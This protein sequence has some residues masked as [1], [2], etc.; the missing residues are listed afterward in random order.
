[1]RRRF[2]ATKEDRAAWAKRARKDL[3]RFGAEALALNPLLLEKWQAA[4]RLIGDADPMDVALHWLQRNEAGSTLK[5]EEAVR[6]YIDHVEH[7]FASNE[8]TTRMQRVLDRFSTVAAG[9]ALGAISTE[10]IHRWLMAQRGFKAKTRKN[11]RADLSAFFAYWVGLEALPANPVDGVPVPRDALDEPGTVSPDTARR[12]FEANADDSR[13]TTVLALMCFAGMRSSAISRLEWS[14]LRLADEGILTSA[15]KSKKERRQFLQGFPPVL[16]EWLKRAQA[17]HF[18]RDMPAATGDDYADRKAL[19]AW[20]V[21]EKRR[22]ENIRRR[23]LLRSGL[24]FDKQ[25]QAD[26]RKQH[27]G[28][29]EPPP[30]KLLPHNWARHSF[31]TYHLAAFKDPGRT[32]LLMSHKGDPTILHDHYRGIRT[33]AEAQA[34]FN[35]RPES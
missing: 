21:T 28:K 17:D 4:Q 16:W 22:L 3:A 35:I 5:F 25:A 33:E 23:A 14:D 1:M 13:A 32:A 20:K 27:P 26:W 31:A 2:F 10:L 6:D 19:N 9:M 29:G 24:F 12:L 11:W 8:R 18:A 30:L 7:R 15:K 34:Y